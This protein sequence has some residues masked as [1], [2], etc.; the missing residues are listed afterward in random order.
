MGLLSKNKAVAAESYRVPPL[1]TVPEYAALIAKRAELLD[2]QT[3]TIRERRK[4][5]QGLATAPVP[6]YRAG[7]ASLLGEDTVAQTSVHGR[8]SELS[9]LDR[10]VTAALTVLD[11]R[12]R[13]ARGRA[14]RLVCDE[15]RPEYGRRVAALCR[16]MQALDAERKSY[17]E[18]R[19]Q[20]E[21][22][23]IAWST[24]RPMNLGWMGNAFDGGHIEVFLKNAREAGYYGN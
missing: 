17:D 11:Q 8:L 4:L 24:L 10:D 9:Q 5:E 19:S 6:A 13:E 3:A 16:A 14:S 12:L 22:E 15:V 7:V 21:V 2:K 20:L 1:T 18:L 23:D